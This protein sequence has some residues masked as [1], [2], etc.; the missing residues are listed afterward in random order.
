MW[1]YRLPYE[2]IEY[3]SNII[4][5]GAGLIGREYVGQ[6]YELNYANIIAVVDKMWTNYKSESIQVVGIEKIRKLKFD[7]IIIAIKS[8]DIRDEVVRQLHNEYDIS[9]DKI[10]ADPPVI[11]ETNSD[12]IYYKSPCDSSCGDQAVTVAVLL[13]KGIGDAIISKRFIC[14]LANVCDENISIDLY[15][16]EHILEF[17]KVLFSDAGYIKNIY[18]RGTIPFDSLAY[19][20]DLA[21]YPAYILYVY[22]V[23]YISMLRKNEK[24]AEKISF[25]LQQLKKQD[26]NNSHYIENSILFA[27]CKKKGVNA[28][29]YYS[30]DGL[31]DIKDTYV[32]IPMCEKYKT[33]F[34]EINLPEKFITINFGWGYN[35]H[36]KEKNYI[37]NKVWPIK[38]Y[39]EFIGF[40]KKKY[41]DISIVQLGLR[42]S[43][44]IKGVNQYIF[45]ENIEVVKYILQA[46]RLHVDCEGGLVHIATQLGTKCAVLF[47]PTPAHYFGYPQNINIVSDVC[48]D[49]YYLDEDYSVCYRLLEKPECMW[50]ITATQVMD[51]IDGYLSS[52]LDK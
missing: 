43:Y 48:S 4:I 11:Y 29:T 13:G 26:Y 3:G 6:I 1:K 40:F 45:D 8:K 9:I 33:R 30:F 46:S 25:M 44:R 14:E 34:E 24:F 18:A 12:I 38:R 41:P 35:E 39:E 37:P 5:Y 23:N 51:A 20:Y 22:N 7:K 15:V 21:I 42:D 52:V 47:G 27:R 10:I 16:D 31:F 50:G 19:N 49:C 32:H 2:K 36:E 17:C 28:Y